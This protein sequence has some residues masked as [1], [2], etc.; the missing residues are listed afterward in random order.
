VRLGRRA[1]GRYDIVGFDEILKQPHDLLEDGVRAYAE[2]NAAPSP[3][4]PLDQQKVIEASLLRI[5]GGDTRL[6]PVV[7]GSLEKVRLMNDRFLRNM[8]DS[9][10]EVLAEWEEIVANAGRNVTF[11]EYWTA[12][13]RK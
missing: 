13:I 6:D 7:S 4:M 12:D 3:I 8:T 5:V 10:T 2:G 9:R 1:T 11:E